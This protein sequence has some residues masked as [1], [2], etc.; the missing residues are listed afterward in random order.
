[1]P[2]LVQQQQVQPSQ[3]PK[4]GETQNQ[5]DQQKPSGEAKGGSIYEDLH[6]AKPGEEGSTS[7]P[8]TWREDYAKGDAK[9]LETLKR[10]AS[11]DAALDSLFA[12]RHRISSGEFKQVTQAPD[13]EKD[14]EGYS[15]WREE[16]GLPVKPEDYSIL[17]K[18][19]AADKLDDVGKTLLSKLQSASHK[20]NLTLEQAKGQANF[21]YEMAQEQMAQ[22]T[23]ADADR[24]DAA[25]D[26]LRADWGPDY[27][28]N[29]AMNLS[30]TKKVF[31]DDLGE[32]LYGA[33]LEDGTRL[34]DIPDFSRAVNGWARSEGGDVFIGGAG[35]SKTAESRI[36]EIEGY[37]ANDASKYTPAVAV[38]YG[39][40]IEKREARKGRQ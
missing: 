16:S 12:A 17:P 23:Q 18:E 34:G 25:Q 20:S 11:P 22:Q 14:A 26:N 32:A 9:K 24:A 15:K 37:L 38:E 2:E 13:Q 6:L 29:I 7:Y 40:L 31:G 8:T 28:N 30:H 39:N 1:M 35:E 4:P 19:V 27:R 3:Q 5:Q 10:F 21:W 36:A 33:R